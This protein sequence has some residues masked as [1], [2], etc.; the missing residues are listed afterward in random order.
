MKN[1][2]SLAKITCSSYKYQKKKR[3]IFVSCEFGS[4]YADLNNSKIKILRPKKKVI[5]KFNFYRNDMFVNEIKNFLDLIENKGKKKIL[6]S[7]KE[8]SFVNNLAIKIKV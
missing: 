4:I 7:I 5:K 8:D 3:T 2:I 6:P 1:N